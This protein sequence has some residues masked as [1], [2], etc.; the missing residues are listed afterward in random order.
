MLFD[1]QTLISVI[2]NRMS[3]STICKILENKGNYALKKG[4]VDFQIKNEQAWNENRTL[5]NKTPC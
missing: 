4:A 1:N 5:E 2:C 3:S